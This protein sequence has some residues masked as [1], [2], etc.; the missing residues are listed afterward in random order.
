[1]LL[2]KLKQTSAEHSEA[3]GPVD[4]QEE[5]AFADFLSTQPKA[6]VNR[7]VERLT[8]DVT[9]TKA[10]AY[11]PLDIRN[12]R[13]DQSKL[14]Q[15]ASKKALITVPVRKPGK[16]DY[17][18]V[19]PD[20][21]H[22]LS[23]QL[24]EYEKETYVVAPTVAE[25]ILSECY[26]AT[27]FTSINRQGDLFLWPVKLETEGSGNARSWYR[28]AAIAADMAR[29]EWVRVTANMSLGAY[30]VR[31]VQINLPEPEWQTHSFQ[32][33]IRI[34]FRDTVI[35]SFDHI[36]LKKLRGEA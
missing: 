26:P 21:D 32:D 14:N 9:A 22:S 2:E 5:K 16:Q 33:L 11:D 24:L 1:M 19:H 3:S 4:P 7:A 29:K 13:L 25:Q 23:V 12:L 35:D 30:E 18:R 27:L 17:I 15:P 34:A 28:S 20:N 31:A 8:Q 36:V 6:V 10:E